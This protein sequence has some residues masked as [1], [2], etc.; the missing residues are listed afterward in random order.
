MKV[1]PIYYCLATLFAGTCFKFNPMS[2]LTIA[3]RHGMDVET[4]RSASCKVTSI[5]SENRLMRVT[6]GGRKLILPEYGEYHVRLI[7]T[8]A[9]A[10][11]DPTPPLRTDMIEEGKWG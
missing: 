5:D 11:V 7:E 9:Y 6:V 4:V 10:Y 2:A 8:G 1:T 3:K